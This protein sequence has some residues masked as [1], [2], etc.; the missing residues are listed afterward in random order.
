MR[1]MIELIFIYTM[2]AFSLTQ[3][4]STQ[5]RTQ[6]PPKSPTINQTNIGASKSVHDTATSKTTESIHFWLKIW[7]PKIWKT[8]LFTIWKLEH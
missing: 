4:K 2:G 5:Y 7:T 3:S 1:Y 6:N 8:N